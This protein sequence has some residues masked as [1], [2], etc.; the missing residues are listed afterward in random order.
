MTYET[1]KHFRHLSRPG[2]YFVSLDPMDGYYTLGIREH[3]RYY[4]TLNL[5]TTTVNC[6]VS[7][8][9]QWVVRVGLFLLQANQVFT[10]QLRRPT[11]P[12]PSSTTP[13]QRPSCDSCATLVG[14][15]HDCLPTWTISSSSPTLKKPR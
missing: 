5:S 8:D 13:S 3:D 12:P 14:A 2:D 9:Y 6:G 1:L 11:S 15:E 7:H 10:S 4:F